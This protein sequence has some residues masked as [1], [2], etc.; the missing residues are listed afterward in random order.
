MQADEQN[1]LFANRKPD[2]ATCAVRQSTGTITPSLSE[3]ITL[4][5]ELAVMDF[6]EEERIAAPIR[7]LVS[8]NDC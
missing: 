7:V 4:L 5:A 1:C 8:G 2:D 6:L 3:L